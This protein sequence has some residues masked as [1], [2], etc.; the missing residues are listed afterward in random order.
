MERARIVFLIRNIRGSADKSLDKLEG[1]TART[2][3]ERRREL[4]PEA[5]EIVVEVILRNRKKQFSLHP[6]YLNPW[7]PVV[8]GG[9][10]VV[11]GKYQGVLGVVKEEKDD[12]LLVV[13][14]TVDDDSRDFVLGQSDL[15]ATAH[16]D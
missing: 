7:K 1:E 12:G 5:G 11:Q 3:P 10:V 6:K 14:F 9:A 16:L 13:T 8:G 2:L 4:V 15:A